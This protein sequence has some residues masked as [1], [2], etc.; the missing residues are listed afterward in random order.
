[1]ASKSYQEVNMNLEHIE[2]QLQAFMAEQPVHDAAH[3]LA[4]IK[5]VV[6]TAKR[7][8]EIEGGEHN[9][10]VPAAWLHDCVTFAKSDPRNKQASTFAADKAIELLRELNYPSE[11][12]DDIHH[13]IKT[14]SYSANFKAETLSAKIVQDADRLDG[15]GAVGVSRCMLVAGKL[16]SKL[17]NVDDPFCEVRSADSKVAAI[18]HFYEKLFKTADTMQTQAGLKE[19]QKRVVFMKQYLAQLALEI[20]VPFNV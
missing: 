15:L 14:H 2:V 9:V 8:C 4:H 10:V 7:L 13:A 5:R 11:Y 19:A 12:L 1:M 6:V 16:G 3:D 18:D 17:Y 20:D